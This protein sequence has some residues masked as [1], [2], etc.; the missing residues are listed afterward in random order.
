MY[1]QQ[2]KQTIDLRNQVYILSIIWMLL[3]NAPFYLS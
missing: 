3:Q 1:N 2:N